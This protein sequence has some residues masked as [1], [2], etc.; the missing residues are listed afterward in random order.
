MRK[1]IYKY[2]AF[3]LAVFILTTN[4]CF[5]YPV[6]ADTNWFNTYKD[7]VQ[8]IVD[9]IKTD[10]NN[11]LDSMKDALSL[12]WRGLGYIVNPKPR[13]IKDSASFILSNE[14]LVSV[15]ILSTILCTA[16]L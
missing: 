9:N 14:L 11:S 2:T 1:K 12:I 6:K 5:S 7:A 8:S 13:H 4:I 3:I 15:F 16:S 10:T